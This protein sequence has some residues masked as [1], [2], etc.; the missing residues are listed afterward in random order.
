VLHKFS[1]KINVDIQWLIFSR[2]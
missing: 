2:R 1:V